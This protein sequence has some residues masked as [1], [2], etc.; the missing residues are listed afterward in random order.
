MYVMLD[1]EGDKESRSV[2]DTL[3]A[4]AREPTNLSSSVV[5]GFPAFSNDFRFC[6]KAKVLIRS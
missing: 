2:D 6:L 5:Q 3:Q 1:L 4:G